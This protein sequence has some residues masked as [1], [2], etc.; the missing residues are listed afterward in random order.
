MRK[1]DSI[2]VSVSPEDIYRA[3]KFRENPIS[4]ALWKINNQNRKTEKA[5]MTF[6]YRYVKNNK[7]SGEVEAWYWPSSDV[8]SSVR[9]KTIQLPT[10]A[11]RF[12]DEFERTQNVSPFHF[13]LIIPNI[14]DF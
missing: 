11:K 13:Y 8:T 7:K 6:C 14:Y 4:C 2:Y 1:L 5:Y 9:C 12:A 3:V 10:E